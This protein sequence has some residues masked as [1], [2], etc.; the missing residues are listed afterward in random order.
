MEQFTRDEI[1]LLCIYDV[2][3]RE[4]LILNLTNVQKELGED[5]GE[6]RQLMDSALAKLHAMT[7]EEYDAISGELVP[8]W[9]A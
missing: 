2:S 6:L 7:D 9:E 4:G 5:D 1:N 8:D 3:K